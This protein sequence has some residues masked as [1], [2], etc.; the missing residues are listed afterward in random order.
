[1]LGELKLQD[2]GIEK[3]GLRYYSFDELKPLL[4]EISEQ[5]R[6][7]GDVKAGEQTA[8]QKQVLK[9]ANALWLYQR[10]KVTLQPEGAA[11]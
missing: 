7:A 5:A 3:S 2:Q 4:F 6:K 9:L 11:G 1:M 10:L 8:F